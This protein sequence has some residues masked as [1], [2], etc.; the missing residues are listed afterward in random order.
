MAEPPS[1]P[2]ES[3]ILTLKGHFANENR[4]IVSRIDWLKKVIDLKDSV[5]EQYQNK[6]ERFGADQLILYKLGNEGVDC[7]GMK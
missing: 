3:K 7:E 5:K 6:L 4:Y 1:P 2:T